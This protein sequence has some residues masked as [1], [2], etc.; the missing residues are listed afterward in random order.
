MV[1]LFVFTFYLTLENFKI[2]LITAATFYEYH[3]KISI[4]TRE[5]ASQNCLILSGYD[6]LNIQNLKSVLPHDF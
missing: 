5:R 4:A 1:E 3:S 2:N 6:D